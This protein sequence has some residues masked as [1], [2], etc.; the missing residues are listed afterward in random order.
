MAIR[1]SAYW[2]KL[3]PLSAIQVDEQLQETLF[4]QMIYLVLVHL[5]HPLLIKSFLIITNTFGNQPTSLH[6]MNQC[7]LL[8][9]LT[10]YL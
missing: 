1:L 5:F 4:Q 7:E 9:V 10:N 8:I 2:E 3:Q 6:L